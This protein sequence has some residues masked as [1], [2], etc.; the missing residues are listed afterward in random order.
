MISFVF[1]PMNLNTFALELAGTREFALC[2]MRLLA[3]FAPIDVI[4]IETLQMFNADF[5]NTAYH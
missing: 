4:A 5:G 2:A 1:A 3:A